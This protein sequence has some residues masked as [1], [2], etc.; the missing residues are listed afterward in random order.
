MALI[1][2]GDQVLTKNVYGTDETVLWD[3]GYT[4]ANMQVNVTLTESVLT[5]EKLKVFCRDDANRS[6]IIEIDTNLSQAG[7]TFCIS[8]G[9]TAALSFRTF[10]VKIADKTVSLDAG[11][12]SI[13]ASNKAFAWVSPCTA[14][15]SFARMY[16]IIGVNRKEGV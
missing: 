2:N 16:K 4:W 11:Q 13:S 12:F 15:S 7:N 9:D 10:L 14:S 5:F 6:C 8:D 1:S 3:V